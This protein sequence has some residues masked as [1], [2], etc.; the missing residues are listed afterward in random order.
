M[1]L[2]AGWLALFIFVWVIGVFLGSTF[3]QEDTSATWAGSGN[4]S[5]ETASINNLQT[6]MSSFQAVQRNP[7]AGTL[8]MVVNGDFWSAVF[9]M[10]TWQWSFLMNED[11]SMAYGMFYWIFLFRSSYSTLSKP[12]LSSM[13]ACSRLKPLLC[14]WNGP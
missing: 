3:E 9:K 13:W 11:G 4:S 5:Y 1:G 8:S 7:I 10:I 12:E 14:V 6:V 2:K